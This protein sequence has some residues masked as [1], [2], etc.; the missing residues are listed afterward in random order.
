[1]LWKSKRIFVYYTH[2]GYKINERRKK[3]E[4]NGKKEGMCSFKTQSIGLVFKASIIR[5]KCKINVKQRKKN[6]GA[7]VKDQDPIT[8]GHNAS[9]TS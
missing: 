9:N 6:I 7:N 8:N 3:R 5:I 2:F 1:M 4:A